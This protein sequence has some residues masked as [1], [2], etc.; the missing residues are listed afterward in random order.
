M[1]KDYMNNNTLSIRQNLIFL[2]TPREVTAMTTF[3]TF[4]SNVFEMLSVKE[5]F[6][7]R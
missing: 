5:F 7:M 3:L 6:N 4:L 2:S 1:Q